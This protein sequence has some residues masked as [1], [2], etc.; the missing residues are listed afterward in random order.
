[1]LPAKIKITDQILHKLKTARIEKRIP[2]GSLSRAINRDDSYISS[3]ELGR[4]QSISSVDLVAIIRTL[5]SISGEEAIAKATDFIGMVQNKDDTP[6][7]SYRWAAT[8]YNSIDDAMS[9]NEST[10]VY[11]RELKADYY[12][13]ELINDMLDNLTSL[14]SEFYK[15]D[16][17]E[18]VFA[19]N[20]FV[21]TMQFDPDFTMGVMGLPFFSLKALSNDERMEALPDIA[22]VIKRLSK[23][24]AAWTEDPA[25]PCGEELRRIKAELAAIKQRF[26]LDKQEAF[27]KAHADITLKEFAAMLFGRDREPN[28]TPDEKLL[29]KQRGFVVVYGDSDDRVEFEGAIREEGHTNPLLKN[30]PAGV[31]VLSEDGKLLDDE[32]DLYAEYI[33]KNRNVIK[34]YYCS[35]DGL[36]WVFESDIPHETFLTYDGGYDEEFSDFDEGFARC[37]VFEVSSLKLL[38]HSK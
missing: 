6:P 22:A 19:L 18:A 37:M 1:M 4:L 24:E 14:I 28:M 25:E 35:K 36:N 16:P 7:D 33:K 31:L 21:K 38:P 9:V 32:S 12:E 17:K 2:A 23:K 11:H 27:L 13:T 10:P 20:S 26:G 30:R 3:L 8:Q 34:V 15:K 5:F 29:A